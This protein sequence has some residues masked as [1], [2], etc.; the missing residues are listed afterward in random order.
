MFC[1]SLPGDSAPR[2]R[3]FGLW[4]KDCPIPGAIRAGSTDVYVDRLYYSGRTISVKIDNN[5]YS[6]KTI[7]SQPVTTALS[8]G[9]NG[10]YNPFYENSYTGDYWICEYCGKDLSKTVNFSYQYLMT[11]LVHINY[12]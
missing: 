10:L 9:N 1:Y 12:H 5:N 3:K 7:P 11:S 4:A 2:Y 6:F 8:M